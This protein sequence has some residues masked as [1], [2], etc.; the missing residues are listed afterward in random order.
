MMP[1]RVVEDNRS[2]TMIDNALQVSRPGFDDVSTVESYSG[3]LAEA[4]TEVFA[5]MVMMKVETLGLRSARPDRLIDSVSA[6]LGISGGL[7][8]VL[9]VHCPEQVA[10]EIC[11]GM[12]GETPVEVDAEV[13]DTIGEMVNMI[14]GGL[15]TRLLQQQCEIELAVPS[16]IAGSCYEV[17][18]LSRAE[19]LLLPFETAAGTFLLE[20]K[21][22]GKT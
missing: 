9:A 8:G 5:T 14:A 11:G 6:V 1:L 19:R 7:R 10:R 2:R 17:N 13:K 12:L 4:T 20:F 16:V 18:L 22:A 3:M 15:K 21:Y